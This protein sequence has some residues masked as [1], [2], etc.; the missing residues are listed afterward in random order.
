MSK[1]L[2][3]MEAQEKVIWK[4]SLPQCRNRAVIG[5]LPA[6]IPL[7]T[8][9]ALLAEYNAGMWVALPLSKPLINPCEH[10]SLYTYI[11]IYTGYHPSKGV[12]ILQSI[13][14]IVHFQAII[15]LYSLPGYFPQSWG[16]LRRFSP[17]GF[18]IMHCIST[19]FVIVSAKWL[20][21]K[22][23]PHHAYGVSV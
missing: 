9:I 23:K 15:R 17:K 1:T 22:I 14:G 18:S 16:A 4:D 12:A 10:H 21:F 2:Q 8:T 3:L 19:N 20:S 6:D 7:E 11:L 5:T 13:H